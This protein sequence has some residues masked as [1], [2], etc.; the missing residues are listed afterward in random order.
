MQSLLVLLMLPLVHFLFREARLGVA[1]LVKVHA[2]RLRTHLVLHE[3]RA[4]LGGAETRLYRPAVDRYV[5]HTLNGSQRVVVV[6]VGD[7]SG[8]RRSLHARVRRTRIDHHFVDLPVLAE[9]FVLLQDLGVG[10]SRRQPDD[11]HEILLNYSNVR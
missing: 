2:V 7:V 11:K 8:S 1:E 9:V 3:M 6:D 10:E 5:V 4:V